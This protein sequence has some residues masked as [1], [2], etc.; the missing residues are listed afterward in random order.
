MMRVFPVALAIATVLSL[1]WYVLAR[2]SMR[3][4]MVGEIAARGEV[5]AQRDGGAAVA[6]RRRW[7]TFSMLCVVTL[8]VL[9][10]SLYVI[11]S[12]QFD[13]SAQKWAYSSVGTILGFWLRAVEIDV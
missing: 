7:A 9:A 5:L 3:R 2:R 10:A 1:T 12:G 8:T 4:W 13:Q 11:L 6:P